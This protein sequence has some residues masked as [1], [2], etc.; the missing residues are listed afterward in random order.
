MSRNKDIELL[1]VMTGC[2]YSYLRT[3]LKKNRWDFWR[4]YHEV[5]DDAFYRMNQ[6][7]DS[8]TAMFLNL[9]EAIKPA[10]VA[11]QKMSEQLKEVLTNEDFGHYSL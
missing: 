4:T 5:L 1:H 2:N 11:V 6:A 8:I 3:V 7:T 10:I 9:S